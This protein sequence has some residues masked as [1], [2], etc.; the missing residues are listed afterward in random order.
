MRQDDAVSEAIGFILIFSIVVTGI[1]I[2]VLYGLPLI[3]AGQSGADV[4][5]ME[6]TMIVLQNDFKSLSYK[7]V[8]YK[9][10]ALQVQGGVLTV[11]DAS[12]SFVVGIG[13]TG[14]L[15]TSTPG[16]LRYVADH[17]RTHIVIENGAVLTR[18]GF[19]RGSAMIAEPR[20]YYD[21]PSNTLIL[22]FIEIDTG[23][24]RSIA[25]VGRIEMKGVS[26]TTD[27]YPLGAGEYVYL[28]YTE[29]PEDDYSV[30]WGNYFTERLGF[31]YYGGEYQ[32]DH[33]DLLVIRTVVI[34][35][36]GF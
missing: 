3:V 17:D 8:P 25:G 18:P 2:V 36:S 20:W 6:Q 24:T 22:S 30:A 14:D 19:A 4:R 27:E 9:E 16:Q 31:V 12:G 32:R 26:V 7:M 13:G 33:V 34:R 28:R 1:A 11:T 35:V 29:D 21:D 10:T 5:N 23:R 15:L